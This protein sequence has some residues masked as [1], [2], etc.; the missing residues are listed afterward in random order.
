MTP[1]RFPTP[2]DALG[3]PG[4]T[5]NLKKKKKRVKFLIELKSRW[6]K[7]INWFVSYLFHVLGKKNLE[8]RGVEKASKE[9]SGLSSGIQFFSIDFC[10]PF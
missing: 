9:L 3:I 5:T 6:A 10:F 2:P 1:P 7:R 4:N 8:N